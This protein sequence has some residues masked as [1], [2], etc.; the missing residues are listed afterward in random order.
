MDSIP[1]KLAKKNGIII[2]KAKY[3]HYYTMGKIVERYMKSI[4]NPK[5][6][7]LDYIDDNRVKVWLIGLPNKLKKMMENYDKTR[8]DR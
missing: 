8:V 2:F 4:N 6:I 5:I 7:S 1:P 3:G